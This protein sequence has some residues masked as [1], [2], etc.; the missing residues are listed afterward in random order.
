MKR[1]STFAS[2]IVLI[3]ATI[4]FSTFSK[5]SAA[6]S[7][8]CLKY[9]GTTLTHEVFWTSYET[10]TFLQTMMQSHAW[11]PNAPD[12]VTEYTAHTTTE[13]QPLV[14]ALYNWA[15]GQW[16]ILGDSNQFALLES[17]GNMDVIS[18]P[19]PGACA[20]DYTLS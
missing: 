16:S 2:L 17:G 9:P 20:E 10:M 15:P 19:N 11:G 13:S 1:I 4:F 8:Y 6:L 5:Q 14:H 7:S 12:G 3:T 18:N